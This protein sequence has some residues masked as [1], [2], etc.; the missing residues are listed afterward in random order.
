MI[1]KQLNYTKFVH[2]SESEIFDL[3]QSTS[4]EQSNDYRN[5]WFELTEQKI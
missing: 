2:I 4:L 3:K 5:I 1:Q